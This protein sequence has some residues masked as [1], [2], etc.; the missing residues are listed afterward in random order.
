MPAARGD[1]A[2]GEL[3]PGD[4]SGQLQ[5]HKTA[6]EGLERSAGLLAGLLAGL[7]LSYSCIRSQGRMAPPLLCSQ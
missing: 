4:L 3:Y 2:V 1:K 6:L 5:W 7:Q